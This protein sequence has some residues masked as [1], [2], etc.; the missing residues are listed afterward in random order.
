MA[1][2]REA[3]KKAPASRAVAKKS[4]SKQAPVDLG[5]SISSSAKKAKGSTT[6]GLTANRPTSVRFYLADD[7]RQEV[8]GKVT[9]V[10]LYTDNVIV[11]EMLPDDPDPSDERLAAVGGISIL[12]N[13]ST[14]PGEHKYQLEID[15]SS[16]VPQIAQASSSHDGKSLA[17]E[18]MNL[19]MRIAPLPFKSFGMVHVVLRI[20]GSPHRF[21]FEIRRRNK[22]ALASGSSA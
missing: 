3:P 12:A 13:V 20:D 10:G 22:P 4:T 9:A 1:T 11:A 7:M 2:K 6:E 19:I 17:G 14:S 16:V 5:T 8:G 18:S 21:S 15:P